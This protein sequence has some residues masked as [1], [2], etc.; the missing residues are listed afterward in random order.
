[1]TVKYVSSITTPEETKQ[2]PL[3]CQKSDLYINQN[4]FDKEITL[5]PNHNNGKFKAEIYSTADQSSI[6]RFTNPNGQV[7]NTENIYLNQGWAR[8]FNLQKGAVLL[9]I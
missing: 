5:Y 3:G 1:L 4:D 2:F 8:Y 9:S 7:L 6:F